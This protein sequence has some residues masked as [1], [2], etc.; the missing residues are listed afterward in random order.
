MKQIRTKEFDKVKPY[1]YLIVRK[2]DNK[3]YHG[4][5]WGNKKSPSEDLGKIY[6]TSSKYLK[7][8]LKNNPTNFY[9]K[10][11]WTFNSVKEARVYESKVNEKIYKKKDWINKNAFPAIYNEIPTMLGKKHSA[12][13]RRKMSLWQNKNHPMR[14][15]KH[16]EE[17][18]K[19][20]GMAGLGRKY[21]DESKQKMSRNRKGKH[22]GKEHKMFGK[23]LS[24]DHPFVILSRS[25]KGTSLSEDTKKKIS[26]ANKGKQRS[27]EFHKK[28]SLIN[29]GKGNPMFGKKHNKETIKKMKKAA[30]DRWT[31]EAKT[32]WSGLNHHNY[33]KKWSLEHKEKIGNSVRGKNNGMFG[34]KHK[35]ETI[36]KMKK[37]KLGKKASAETIKK[38][39]NRIPW[40]K[41]RKGIQVPWNKGTKGLMVAWNKG[42]KKEDYNKELCF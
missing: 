6:F 8:D 10:L 27:E 17:T 12:E 24:A 26:R 16:K 14:G 32:S 33:G 11:S 29:N 36:E 41:G 22:S 25:R 34:K 20:I 35:L 39:K 18:K 5:R 15:K 3:K 28:C 30:A 38:L 2:S 7:D 4:V 40:N 31:E 1:T 13:S 9:F 23:K 37:I 42:L 19:K 21:S